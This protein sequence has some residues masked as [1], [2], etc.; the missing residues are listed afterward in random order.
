[1]KIT[2]I[3]FIILLSF[4][5]T[6]FAQSTKIE[7]AVRDLLEPEVGPGKQIAACS[8]GVV[9]GDDVQKFS[10]GKFDESD[11]RTPD[12][13]TIYEIASVSKLFTGLLLADMVE[14][15][16]VRLDQPLA[17]I[18][19]KGT[20][21][22]ENNAK[23]IT[24]EDIATHTS[25]LPRLA[26][27]FW[28]VANQ[29]PGNPYSLYTTEKVFESLG[30]W[31]PERAP[32]EKYEYSNY[33]YALLGNSL[34]VQ[35]NTTY[36][37]LLRERVLDPLKMKDT[38]VIVSEANMERLAPGHDGNGQKC[39]NWDLTGFAP[40]GGL[41]SD[42]DEMTRF[43]IAALGR[44]DLLEKEVPKDANWD[45]LDKAFKLAMVPRADSGSDR[46]VGLG[47]NYQTAGKFH[48]HNGQTGGYFSM[49]VVDRENKIGVV[50]LTNSFNAAPDGIAVQI[51]NLLRKE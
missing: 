36:E 18:L 6:T 38:T 17:Y 46:K 19:P 43:A 7:R 47:W 27:K 24:L 23:E 34:A 31:K 20:V 49:F 35:E 30:Q 44:F 9:C 41:H 1:M 39:G 11:D 29:T 50:I 45:N 26:P 42:I 37:A 28:D 16:E 40:G 14:R 32:K 10:F 13:Q 2:S 5:A 25:G 4:C 22:P 8:V 33:A 21:F 15:G 3:S 51:L 12:S 48:W